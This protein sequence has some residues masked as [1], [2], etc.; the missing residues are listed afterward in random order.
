MRWHASTVAPT[1]ITKL[2]ADGAREEASTEMA[3]HVTSTEPTT[4]ISKG[5]SWSVA[6]CSASR[7]GMVKK[8]TIVLPTIPLIQQIQ[9][10]TITFK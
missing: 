4:E 1:A 8:S 6:S 10:R 2:L 3:K 7:M 5:L 9:A